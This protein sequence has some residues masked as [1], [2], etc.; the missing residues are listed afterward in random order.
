MP[1]KRL[2]AGFGL[3]ELPIGYFGQIARRGGDGDC[4]AL[5]SASARLFNM[6]VENS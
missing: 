3:V 5:A 6:R 1:A 2:G 4:L